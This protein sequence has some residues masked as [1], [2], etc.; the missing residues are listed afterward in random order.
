MWK[1][2]NHFSLILPGTAL[3]QNSPVD[4]VL[5]QLVQQELNFL[6]VSVDNMCV[7]N[8]EDK[9]KVAKALR[10]VEESLK[11]MKKRVEN[12]EFRVE[13]VE[14]RQDDFEGALGCSFVSALKFVVD[15]FVHSKVFRRKMKFCG[16][17]S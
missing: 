15:H 10:T 1:R 11:E 5:L 9:T 14:R 17:I 6:Q 13:V 16:V 2:R 8:E 3:C 12:L 7:E 4:P